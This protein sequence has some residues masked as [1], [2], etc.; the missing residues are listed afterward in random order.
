MATTKESEAEEKLLQVTAPPPSIYY[1]KY[2][3]EAVQNGTAPLPPTPPS[4]EYSAFGIA[5]NVRILKN[6]QGSFTYDVITQRGEGV[7]K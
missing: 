4:G 2:T 5:H 3:K 6:V 1:K 7:S